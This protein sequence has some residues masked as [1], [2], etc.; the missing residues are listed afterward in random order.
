M[1]GQSSNMLGGPST[2][3]KKKDFLKAAALNKG[4]VTKSAKAANIGRRTYYRWIEEDPEF[5]AQYNDIIESFKDFIIDQGIALITG[6]PLMDERTGEQIG[7]IVKPDA[8][9]VQMFLRTL[10]RDRGF[11]EHSELDVAAH[12]PFIHDS[13]AVSRL[14]EDSNKLK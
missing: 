7:W 2:V 12:I 8:G 5:L 11:T 13:A 6:I 4:N 1:P 9:T 10:C 14:I 3:K